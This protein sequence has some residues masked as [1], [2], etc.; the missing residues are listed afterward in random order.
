MTIDVGPYRFSLHDARK[1][2]SHV[3]DIVDFCAADARPHLAELRDA[4]RVTADRTD[5]TDETALAAAVGEVFPRLLA[6]N[7]TLREAGALPST[8]T[9]RVA[10]LNVSDGGVP[11]LPVDRVEIGYAGVTTDRQATRQHHGRPWQAVCLWSAEVIAEL[12]AAGHPIAP[13]SAGENVTIE[14]ID[15]VVMRS[16]VRL[17]VGSALVQVAAP[18]VPC[19]QNAGWFSDRNFDRI[20][21]RHGPVSRIYATVL[22]PGNVSTGDPVVLEP[23]D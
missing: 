4:L 9:G 12:A 14:G 10:Q 16:G 7:A 20:H 8:V 11:K 18:A 22:E 5:L 6:V 1:T 13:G 3:G 15:W 17:R 19:K 23:A 21:H 2:L